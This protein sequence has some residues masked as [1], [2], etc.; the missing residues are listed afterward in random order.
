L[1]ISGN[2]REALEVIPETAEVFAIRICLVRLG[3]NRRLATRV[4]PTRLAVWS[5]QCAQVDQRA[6]AIPKKGLLGAT[7][8]QVP[9]PG[10]PACI[11]HVITSAIRPSPTQRAEIGDCISGRLG[12]LCLHPG[13]PKD[14]GEC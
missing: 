10:Y 9:R 7:E 1:P 12:T 13:W 8:G 5:T 14:D 4:R 2:G 11:V 6:S 3:K